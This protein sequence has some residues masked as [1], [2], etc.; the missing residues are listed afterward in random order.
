ML[1]ENAYPAFGRPKVGVELQQPCEGA[2]GS[3]AI[4]P[5]HLC[6][7]KLEK[8]RLI[9][10]C[11][12]A[13]TLQERNGVRSVRRGAA[14]HFIRSEFLK[15]GDLPER[16]REACLI[17]CSIGKFRGQ[18]AL[19]VDRPV[20]V[21]A[22]RDLASHGVEA[23]DRPCLHVV[24]DCRARL[25]QAQLR[26]A[27]AFQTRRPA[28]GGLKIRERVCRKRGELGARSILQERARRRHESQPLIEPG[29]RLVVIA[30]DQ[31]DVP[32]IIARERGERSPA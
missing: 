4:A 14:R 15:S 10:G 1:I 5:L 8:V 26:V 19:G 24:A 32:E 9:I 16:A 22:V 30:F 23:R 27:F 20:H 21:A 6:V 25:T 29:E 11:Y 13:G 12:G 28:C 18:L 17:Y 2:P 7:A 31:R 3:V